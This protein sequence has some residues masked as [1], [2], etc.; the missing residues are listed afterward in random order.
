MF[1]RAFGTYKLKLRRDHF[2]P[3]WL[4]IAFAKWP[5]LPLFKIVSFS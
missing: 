5:V 1:L 3:F 4:A 2:W